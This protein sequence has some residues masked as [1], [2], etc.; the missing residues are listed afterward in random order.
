MKGAAEFGLGEM[1]VVAFS[2]QAVPEPVAW[3]FVE[4]LADGVITLLDLALVSRGADDG[5]VT[6]VE[7]ERL[8]TTTGVAAIEATA[9]GLVGVEDVEQTAQSLEPGTSALVVLVEHTWA[10]RI[11]A[12]AESSAARVVR[13]ERFAGPVPDGAT[14]TA[15]LPTAASA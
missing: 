6:V 12:A 2:G 5:A 10:R 4:A 15:G 9:A 1:Y 8:G 14:A 13:T 11:R 7:L 3:A